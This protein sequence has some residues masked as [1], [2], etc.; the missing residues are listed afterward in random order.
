MLSFSISYPD[1]IKFPYFVDTT[2]RGDRARKQRREGVKQR[3]T[4]WITLVQLNCIPWSRT[5]TLNYVFINMLVDWRDHETLQTPFG[6]QVSDT[7][8]LLQNLS[9][10][11][12]DQICQTFILLLIRS[13]PSLGHVFVN[14]H[15]RFW[16]CSLSQFTFIFSFAC[17]AGCYNLQP[18]WFWSHK[19]SPVL[20]QYRLL[21]NIP[22]WSW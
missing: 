18:Y 7:P 1:L 13:Q 4:L 2:E 10:C 19:T 6:L 12:A 17:E 20:V 5:S 14:K 3:V 21:L 9:L 11:I 15:D 16:P 22:A 8:I